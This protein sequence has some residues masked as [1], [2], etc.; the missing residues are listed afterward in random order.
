MKINKMSAYGNL[1]EFEATDT[2]SAGT[3]IVVCCGDDVENEI[4]LNK[5]TKVYHQKKGG[6][7]G[8]TDDTWLMICDGD[9]IIWINDE[10]A[11]INLN[12]IEQDMEIDDKYL[13]GT[14]IIIHH[15]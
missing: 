12:E 5:D 13:D 7:T 10:P 3:K 8:L 4:I 6:H 11:E 14:W 1:E 15:N 2:L 9:S